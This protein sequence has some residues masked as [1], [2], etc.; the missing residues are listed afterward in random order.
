MKKLYEKPLLEVLTITSK[1]H[2]ATISGASINVTETLGTVES[3]EGGAFSDLFG[4]FF[5]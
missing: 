5:G 4:G 1:A 2:F 3:T